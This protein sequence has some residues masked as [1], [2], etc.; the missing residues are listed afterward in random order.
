MVECELVDYSAR[1]E[2]L[3]MLF[4]KPAVTVDDLAAIK[5][6]LPCQWAQVRA[7]DDLS[8]YIV[9]NR[10]EGVKG[11]LTVWHGKEKACIDTGDGN[12]WGDWKED[13]KLIVTEEYEEAKDVA[14]MEVMGRIAYNA[15]GVRGIYSQRRFFTLFD[16][17]MDATV[18]N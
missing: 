7:G 4:E 2:S 12:V 9:D 17:A 15:H 13:A 11:L 1:P 8:I 5:D 14:G 10:T 6:I 16:Y 18:A 3:I